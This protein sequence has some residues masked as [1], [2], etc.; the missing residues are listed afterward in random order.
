[1]NTLDKP[2]ETVEDFK[3]FIK[4]NATTEEEA[5]VMILT[6]D[7]LFAQLGNPISEE[8]MASLQNMKTR[9]VEAVITHVAI[10]VPVNQAG[11]HSAALISQGNA[12]KDLDLKKETEEAHR[13][14]LHKL[15]MT[16]QKEMDDNQKGNHQGVIMKAQSRVDTAEKERKAAEAKLNNITAGMEQMGFVAG[17]VERLLAAL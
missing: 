3:E 6:S 12:Q 7:I 5:V 9:M 16:S 15:K 10:P 8:L 14:Q 13:K 2:I 17:P 1:M 11:D 4:S